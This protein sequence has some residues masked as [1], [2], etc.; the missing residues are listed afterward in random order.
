MI[1]LL[2]GTDTLAP[3]YVVLQPQRVGILAIRGWLI[4][5]LALVPLLSTWYIP[6]GDGKGGTLIAG[7]LVALKSDPRIVP[8]VAEFLRHY[9]LCLP[10]VLTVNVVQ[11]FLSCQDVVLPLL[12]FT[13]VTSLGLHPLLLF[14]FVNDDASL[15]FQDNVM[16]KM[17][18]CALCHAGTNWTCLA[19]TMLYL[20]KREGAFDPRTWPGLSA[21][22]L[23]EALLDYHEVVKYLKLSAGGVLSL[24]EWLYWEVLTFMMSSIGVLPLSVHTIGYILTPLLFMIPMGIAIGTTVQVGK[25][26]ARRSVVSAKKITRWSIYLSFTLSILYS[27]LIYVFRRSVIASYTN[28]A[29]VASGALTIWPWVCFFFF[30]DALF[31]IQRGILAALGKQDLMSVCVGVSLWIVGLPLAYVVVYVTKGGVLGLWQIMV[32][33]YGLLNVSMF[34]MWWWWV[35]WEEVSRK[36]IEEANSGAVKAADGHAGMGGVLGGGGGR[37]KKSGGGGYYENISLD[38]EGAD[39]DDD[40]MFSNTIDEDDEGGIEMSERGEWA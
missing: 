8:Y 33:P 20:K 21:G 14:L 4:C 32:V 6:L 28:D 35:D 25:A 16:Q 5:A 34:V 9:A 10:A 36:V 29:E 2:S 38:D 19:L 39:D 37:R 17:K 31:G 12:A 24:S 30:S 27:V 15:S 1:G 26:L 22:T 18:S 11:R 3:Q 7:L 23:R 13:S 40:D